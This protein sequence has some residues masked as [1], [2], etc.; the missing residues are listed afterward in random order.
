MSPRFFVSPRALLLGALLFAVACGGTGSSSS[1]REPDDGGAAGAASAGKAGASGKGGAAGAGAA[2]KAGAAA[3]AGASGGGAAGAAA[4]GGAGAAGTAGTAGTAGSG[5]GEAGQAGGGS[6]GAGGQ[7]CVPKTCK[8]QGLDCGTASD[9]C[10]QPLQCGQ[11]GPGETCGGSG[12]QN[13]CG[14]PPCAAKSCQDQGIA[15][16]PA[17]DG[18]GKALDC[19]TCQNGETCGGGGQ[20][21]VCGSSTCTAKSCAQQGIS[22]G[23]AGDGCGNPLDCGDCPLGL[24]CGGGGTPG[25]CG[26]PKCTPKTCA[27]LGAKSC[28]PVPDGCGG[29]VQCGACGLPETCGGAGKVGECGIPSSCTNLCLQQV[30]CSGGKTTT[31]SG[32]VYAPN[33]VDPLPNAAVYVPNTQVQPFPAGVSCDTCGAPASGSPL[34][35]AVTG[36]DGKF[37]L[38]N[39][40]VGANIPLVVQLGRWRRQVKIPT[41]TKCV[42]TA[43]PASLTRLPKNK[44]E[45]DIPLIA[46]STGAVDALECVFRKIGVDDSEFTSSTSSGRIHLYQGLTDKNST[47]HTTNVWA[48]GGAVAPG[49]LSEDKLWSDPATLHKYDM[50]LFPCQADESTS[51]ALRPDSAKQNLIAYANSGGRVFATHFSYIWFYK[52]A[53]WNGVVDWKVTQPTP[54]NQ[55]GFID[56]SFPRGKALAEWLHD[57][58][59]ASSTYGQIPL[60]FVRHD[61]DHMV[62]P[63]QSWMTIKNVPSYSGSATVHFTFN[64]PIG[65]P[66]DQQCGR[67]LFDDFH[68]E[69]TSF[70]PTVGALFPAECAPGSMTPQE[71]LLEYMIFD[72]ASCIAPDQ[73]V[74]T[75][76]KCSELGIGCGPTGDG[77]G[78]ILQCGDCAPGQTCGGGGTPSQCGAPTCTPKTCAAQ[79]IECGPAGDGCGHAL[80]CGDCPQGQTCGGGGKPGVCG[81]QACSP[82]SCG[83]QG[84]ECGPAGDGCGGALSC[85][86]CPQGQTCGGGGQPGKCGAP[87]CPPKSC[88]DLGVECGP[89]G[90][91]CGHEL[92]CGTCVAPKTC[93]GGG[94]PGKCGGNGKP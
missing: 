26:A 94:V 62:P 81:S 68:V 20:F 33:G 70:A 23:P 77:C 16:G 13:V 21:G 90:D 35:S 65:K 84:I 28:G 63:T 30:S 47:Y 43:L 31:V 25:V 50:V 15:C 91:G 27:D 87:P 82:L 7:A 37:K 3:T 71:K 54:P 18:C 10:G 48:S 60:T 53:P 58:V 46:F 22:C 52:T 55:D 1:T 32:I 29:L 89:A 78:N 72:L 4:G 61:H 5:G 8:D 80:K 76:K 44:T 39:V 85:G 24:S 38:E 67:V 17:G 75:P 45:G 59:S 86:D 2:G 56:T 40:P 11:C 42:D 66:A 57:V 9:G 92:Q 14:V 73:P 49:S 19:G 83:A 51:A 34:V 36:I 74:C 93:G 79:G 6:S 12:K 41:V 69:N 88:A 64:T